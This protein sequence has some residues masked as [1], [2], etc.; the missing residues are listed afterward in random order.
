MEICTDDVMF[1]SSDFYPS[2]GKL[3]LESG[4]FEEGKQYKFPNGAFLVE[5][6]EYLGCYMR[7]VTKVFRKNTDRQRII[8]GLD[9]PSDS[10]GT[11]TPH[12]GVK[13]EPTDQNQPKLP[14]GPIK[15]EPEVPKRAP[16]KVGLTRRGKETGGKRQIEVTRFARPLSTTEKLQFFTNKQAPRL[17]RRI[18]PRSNRL[19]TRLYRELGIGESNAYAGVRTPE[20]GGEAASQN[21]D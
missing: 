6:Q 2:T 12:G 13:E 17:I 18:A 5:F 7:D 19:Y 14:F 20:I 8:N 16:R 15:C 9:L 10:K 11:T 1:V 3:P 21:G 4:A